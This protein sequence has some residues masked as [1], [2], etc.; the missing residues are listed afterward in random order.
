MLTNP[1]PPAG[2]AEDDDDNYSIFSD[3]TQAISQVSTMNPSHVRYG[4]STISV[5]TEAG[6]AF[7]DYQ[8]GIDDDI[9]TYEYYTQMQYNVGDAVLTAHDG[10]DDPVKRKLYHFYPHQLYYSSLDL[11]LFLV[12]AELI[13]LGPLSIHGEDYKTVKDRAR[14]QIDEIRSQEIKD[15]VPKAD[16]PRSLSRRGR[17]MSSA[18][19][20]IFLEKGN[21]ALVNTLSFE[22]L[23]FL[24]I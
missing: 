22:K 2:E 5:N 17:A 4:T 9:S 20:K 11:I 3:L 1:K 18:D 12:P 16:E 6:N 24:Y 23:T 21:K 8:S 15:K 13:Q 19:Q 14:Y 10:S 7:D